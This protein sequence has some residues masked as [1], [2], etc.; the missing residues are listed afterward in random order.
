[1]LQKPEGKKDEEKIVPSWN[2]PAV[3]SKN[4]SRMCTT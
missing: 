4:D 2:A 1:M 3:D